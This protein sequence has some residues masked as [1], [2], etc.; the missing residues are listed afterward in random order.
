VSRAVCALNDLEP[1]TSNIYQPGAAIRSRFF[2]IPLVDFC[3]QQWLP[4]VQTGTETAEIY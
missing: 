2:H 1:V 4:V 3:G